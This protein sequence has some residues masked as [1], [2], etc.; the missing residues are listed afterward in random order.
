[1]MGSGPRLRC[2]S[3]DQ[4]LNCCWNFGVVVTPAAGA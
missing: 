3:A 1:M 4:A 2:E